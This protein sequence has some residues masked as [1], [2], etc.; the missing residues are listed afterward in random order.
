MKMLHL[1]FNMVIQETMRLY[2]SAAFVSTAALQEINLKGI[3]IAEGIN[4]WIPVPM[5]MQD[6]KLWGPD[7]TNSIQK[8]SQMGFLDLASFHKLI[9]SLG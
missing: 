7:A 8:D 1:Q 4:I 9:H 2:P 5:L 6:P 3:I